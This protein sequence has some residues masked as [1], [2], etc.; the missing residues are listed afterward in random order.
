[1]ELAFLIAVLLLGI[2]LLGLIKLREHPAGSFET[3]ELRFGNDLTA[4]A[5]QALLMCVTGLPSNA[6]VVLDVLADANGIRHLLHAPQQTLDTLRGQWRGVLPNLLME[7][8]NVPAVEWSGG[9]LL[10]L[11]GSHPVLRDDEP[12][13]AVAALL[14]AL[15]PLSG[16]RERLLIHWVLG[17]ARRPVLPEGSRDDQRASG[18]LA[19]L[20]MGEPTPRPD[21]LRALR[22]KYAGPLLSGVGMVAVAAGHPKRA[23][24]LLSRVVSAMRPRG[25]AYGQ[26]SVRRR[27]P[28]QITRLLARRAVARPD[29]YAPGELAP[30]TALPIDAPLVAGLTLGVAPVLMPSPRIPSEGRVLGVSNWPGGE[31]P[32]AQ[33]VLGGLQNTLVCG[34]S[35]VGK[36]H[37]IASLAVQQVLA[38]LG[39]LLIDGKGGDLAN[40]VSARIPESRINDVFM[41]EPGRGGPQPGL[42]LFGHGAPELT[43][44]LVVGVMRS[45]YADVWGP[46]SARWLR[47]GLILLAHDP[48]ASLADFPF[49]FSDHAYRR[50]LVARLGDDVLAKATWASFEEMGAAERAHQIQA[51][52]NKVEEIIG[53]RVIRGVLGQ[54]DPQLDMAEVLRTGKIVI[55]SLNAGQIGPAARLLGALAVHQFFLA[56]Q[57]R[58]AIPTAQRHPFLFFCDE[59]GVLESV[60]V[61]LDSLY[62]TARGLGC[63]VLLSAQSLTQLPSELR[64]AATTNS[65]TLVVFR[66]NATDSKLLAPELTNVSSEALQALGKY[67]TVMRVGL[68]P[69]DVSAP[70]TARTLP[71]SEPTIDPE[72]VRQASA[73]RYGVDPAEVDAALAARHQIGPTEDTPVG[74]LRRQ[75]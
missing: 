43:A 1:M 51:P 19:R 39:L 22:A 25:G 18:G 62:E 63:G 34:P 47:A 56:V 10:R 46:M 30:L 35:G 37:L 24:H 6:V 26:I 49:V 48:T 58:A 73:A 5:A 15:Q 40:E 72:V 71:L 59:P 9:A 68:G 31:R 53:R 55:V 50:R 45:L 57:G 2:G 16:E 8:K 32:I 61:P 54:S 7:P 60:P 74:F 12:T 21:H 38:G 67:E 64:A 11:S 41:V 44:D 3:V 14:G 4:D 13:P 20:L 33:P 75:P 28:R 65:S 23:A 69:G 27:G 17:S 42:R 70:V 29:L 36:S 66:Q 52:L